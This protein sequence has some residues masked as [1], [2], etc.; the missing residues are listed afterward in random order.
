RI[1]TLVHGYQ[2]LVREI[3]TPTIPDFAKACIQLLKPP[4]SSQ[5][6]SLPLSAVETIH[7]A[8]S[9]LV[10]LYHTTC[11]T[12]TSQLRASASRFLVP[13]ASD[14]NTVPSTL[15]ASSR[16]LF[17]TL[18]FTDPKSE[19]SEDWARVVNGMLH[20][21]H[22]TADQVFRAVQESWESNTGYKSSKVD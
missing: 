15:Q 19:G 17:V 18:H 21:F 14:D 13:T 4:A 3:A 8:F 9:T 5:P 11:R 6:A 10:P 1:Y 2:T 7:D 22:Q 12:F 16:R 20:E